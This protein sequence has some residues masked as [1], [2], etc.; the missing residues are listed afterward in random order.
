MYNFSGTWLKVRTPDDYGPIRLIQFEGEVVKSFEISKNSPTLTIQEANTIAQPIK[1]EVIDNE[2][3]RF[4]SHGKLI[5]SYDDRNEVKDIIVERDYQ[6]LLPTITNLS[7]IDIEQLKL[8]ITIG[9]EQLNVIF[10]TILDS[11]IIQECNKRIG[12]EGNKM[13]LER[14]EDSLFIVVYSNNYR[15]NIIPIRAID[16]RAVTVYGIYTEPY[17]VT[18]SVI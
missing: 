4:Y 10:N 15:Q 3:I 14:L 6:R 2:R 1:I 12:H 11:A 9:R 5:Q 7:D 13:K 18:G 8:T 17:E 16:K